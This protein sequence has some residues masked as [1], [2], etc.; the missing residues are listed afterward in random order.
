MPQLKTF[1][2]DDD[3][4]SVK[5]SRK[6]VGA[7]PDL[8][9]AGTATDPQEAVPI[10]KRYR[11]ELL[12]LDLEMNPLNGWDVM[13]MLDPAVRV[14]LCTVDKMA[15]EEAYRRQA[16]NYLVKPF[17]KAAFDQAVDRVWAEITSGNVPLLPDSPDYVWVSSGGASHPVRLFLPDIEVVEANSDRS[18]VYYTYGELL[19]DQSLKEVEKLLPMRQ[20]MRIHNSYLIALNRYFRH[21][22]GTVQLQRIENKKKQLIPIGEKY[23]DRF[24]RYLAKQF[25]KK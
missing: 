19:I 21:G 24:Y 6:L 20:F 18:M 4:Q 10:I 15:G 11:I 3:P 22:G 8:F 16:A 13:E 2:L 5:R 9:L 23:A 14:I 17:S 7:R 25:P 12:L 1:I